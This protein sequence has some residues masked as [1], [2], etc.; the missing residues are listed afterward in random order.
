M[1]SGLL[2][3]VV[4]QARRR[5]LL[6]EQHFCVDGTLI[7]VLTDNRH[8]LVVDAETTHASGSAVVG[9]ALAMQGIEGRAAADW[10]WAPTSTTIN[11]ASWTARAGPASCRT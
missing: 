11:D 8:A 5:R 3:A 9:A 6:S 4:E 7:D 2:G 1:T 10:R